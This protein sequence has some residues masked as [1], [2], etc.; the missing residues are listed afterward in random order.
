MN[1]KNLQFYFGGKN[2][3]EI[4][5]QQ[6][7]V[8]ILESTPTIDGTFGFAIADAVGVP[9]E[10]KSRQSLK[11]SPITD[12]VGY[13]THH[14]PEGTWSDDSS[15]TIAT[16]DSINECN[17]IDY[18][19]IMKKFCEWERDSKYTATGV[20]FDIGIST[21]S[22]LQRYSRGTNPKE[23]GGTS[24]RDNGNG[25]LMRILPI[26]LYAHASNLPYEEEVTLINE[27]S[28]LTHGHEI[29]KLGCKIYS[30][31]IKGLLDG[32]SKEDSLENLQNIDYSEY[33][34]VETIEYYKR[35]LD[36]SITSL[37]ENAIKSTGFVVDTLEAS[38]WCTHNSSNYEEAV[39]KAV[40][41]GDDTDTVGAITGSINGIIY[42][43]KSIPKYWRN[44]LKS[45]EYLFEICNNFDNV[46]E[47]KKERNM[48][49]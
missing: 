44:N 35:I 19:D 38:I 18:N 23:C 13:G 36:G 28:S 10:F 15:M 22:A 4:E 39:L 34:S 49:L 33:Y 21:S 8:E 11:M 45:K 2:K 3:K 48:S 26:V 32:K 17:G 25:S 40:N 47:S 9:A 14:M 24:I 16:M 37:P 6:S 7:V 46:L 31:Y 12:M 27:M 20:F 29:S 43:Y 30:D 5:N 41:L 42:G 1:I